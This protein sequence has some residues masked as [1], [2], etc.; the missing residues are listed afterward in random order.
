MAEPQRCGPKWID[1]RGGSTHSAGLGQAVL[2]FCDAA[3]FIGR[4]RREPAANGTRKVFMRPPEGKGG[5]TEPLGWTYRPP[6]GVGECI[7]SCTTVE[8][9]SKPGW[10][11]PQNPPQDIH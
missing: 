10:G 11:V 9:V 5:H 6:G 7:L 4:T 1:S 2:G 8:P 3:G